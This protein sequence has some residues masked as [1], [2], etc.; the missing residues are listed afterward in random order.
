[1]W[2][3]S[4]CVA[5][6]SSGMELMAGARDVFVACTVGIGASLGSAGRGEPTESAV[7]MWAT[8]RGASSGSL[9]GEHR[10]ITGC[11]AC[12]PVA[13]GGVA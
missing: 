8:V 11:V 7:D 2:F 10:S 9:E 3:R 13:S 4:T 1:M 5:L 6:G 12:R